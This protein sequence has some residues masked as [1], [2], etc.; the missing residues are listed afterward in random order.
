MAIPGSGAISM[1]MFNTELGRAS[2]TANSSL[3][4]GT[5]P[6]VGSQFWLGGQSGSLNQTSPHAM[7]EWYNYTSTR[8][9]NL[10]ARVGLA[11]IGAAAFYTSYDNCA[12]TFRGELETNTCTLIASFNPTNESNLYIAVTTLVGLDEVY[13]TFNA[14][15][16]TTTCPSNTSTYC[17]GGYAAALGSTTNIAITAYASKFGFV[18]CTGNV[19]PPTP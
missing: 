19:C 6:A 4:G 11:S 9:V 8:V 2:N 12:Y 17:A 3:A 10:Y 5:T 13:I 15:A 18:E 16:G 14:A 7:S 1:S